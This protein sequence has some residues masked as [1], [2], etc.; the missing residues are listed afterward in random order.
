MA[1]HEQAPTLA[2]GLAIKFPKQ[3]ARLGKCF[4]ELETPPKFYLI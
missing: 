1:P 2:P 4:P 3:I